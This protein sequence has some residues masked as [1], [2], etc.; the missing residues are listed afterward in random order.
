VINADGTITYTPGANFHGVDSFAYTI[1]D[2]N[3]GAGTATVTV[4]IRPVN[5]PPKAGADFTETNEDMPLT[6]APLAN[7]S[8]VDGDSLSVL[9]VGVPA[10]GTAVIGPDGRV[11]YT[12][13]PNYFGPDSFSY[14]VADGAGGTGTGTVFLKVRPVNDAPVA[15]DDAVATDE[16][17]KVSIAVRINDSDVDGDILAVT[18]VSAPAHGTAV[19]TSAS[20]ITY[21]PA[22]N[23]HGVDSFVYMISDGRGG[24]D[25][26]TVNVAVQ[27]VND[28]PSF[29][30][31]GNQT[32]AEDAGTQVVS[33]F[34]TSISPG[35]AD[36]ADQV[37]TFL[38]T[39]DND[40][41]FSSRPVI[42]PSTGA[43][44]YTPA[45]DAYGTATITVR[46]ADDGGTQR[47]G[48]DTSVPQTFI[49]NV[50]SPAQQLINLLEQVLVLATDGVLND[51]QWN[52]L[53]VK[54]THV[55]DNLDDAQPQVALNTLSAFTNQVLDLIED[56]VLSQTTG[57]SLLG[58]AAA[59]RTSLV[60]TAEQHA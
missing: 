24:T 7:D 51:G 37:L 30:L 26:A 4:T 48:V 8:D 14:T 28:A 58:A 19:R 2:G 54:L 12:P 39:T 47:G 16:D 13:S 10:H 53:T 44:T 9:A 20:T 41:L 45:P 57:A 1:A 32:I 27:P 50:L 34:A 29:S 6:F 40:A 59:L 33:A 46:L 17:K 3:G 52:A 60:T 22:P 25:T 38:V 11:T 15:G 35:P 43:L 42:D 23:F 55:Q 21:T 36:E 31:G 5:D 49:I 18:T 56:G